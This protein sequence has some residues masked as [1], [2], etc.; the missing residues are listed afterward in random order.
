MI[1]RLAVL[2]VCAAIAALPQSVSEIEG[3]EKAWQKAVLAKDTAALGRLLSDD[4]FYGH[5]SGI[6]DTKPVY[7]EKL[8]SGRQKYA[9][10]DQR[11]LKIKLHGNTAVTH[12]WVRVTGVNQDGP[13]DDKIMMLH[14][15]VKNAAGWQL[16]GHQT[17][18]VDK[19][20][21]K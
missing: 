11:S 7:L 20:P 4:L 10:F 17:A 2:L 8:K 21:E 19:L 13:F 5:A 9:S 14:V 18:R 15:W 16:A 6:L 12:S 3:L 1:S